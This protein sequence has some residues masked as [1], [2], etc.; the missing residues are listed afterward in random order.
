MPRPHATD[1]SEGASKIERNVHADRPLYHA[2]DSRWF[3]FSVT[4]FD[5]RGVTAS[6]TAPTDANISTWALSDLPAVIAHS[7]RAEPAHL[8]GHSLG[9]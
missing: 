1:R 8:I 5:Y 6:A 7:A 9:G 3:G 4:T 2:A